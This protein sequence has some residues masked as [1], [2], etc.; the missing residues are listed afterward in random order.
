MASS[1]YHPLL[2]RLGFVD[3]A[4]LTEDRS[5]NAASTTQGRTSIHAVDILNYLLTETR[6][7]LPECVEEAY[8]KLSK[9]CQTESRGNNSGKNKIDP[10]GG[11]AL[12]VVGSKEENSGLKAGNS[13]TKM[14]QSSSLKSSTTN[15]STPDPK[16]RTRHIALQ[17]YYDGGSYSGLAEN[18][19]CDTDQSIERALFA[20]LYKAHLIPSSSR[21]SCHYSRCGRTDKGVSAAGQVVALHVKSA[22]SNYAISHN[23]EGTQLLQDDELPKNSFDKI[24]VWVPPREKQ[25]KKKDKDISGSSE[26]LKSQRMQR[27]LSELPYDKILNNLLPPDIRV[28][29]WCPVTADFSARF[30]ATTRTYRYFFIHRP[31]PGLPSSSTDAPSTDDTV[32]DRMRKGLQLMVGTHDFRNFCKMDVE[33]VYNF[34]RTIHSADIVKVSRQQALDVTSSVGGGDICYILIHGQAFLWHQVRCIASILFLVGRG[35]EEPEIVTELL[36]IKKNPGKPSYEMAD[37]RPLVLHDCGYHNLQFGY[38]VQNLWKLCCL[39]EQQWEELALAAARIR[40]TIERLREDENVCVLVDDVVDFVSNR[41]QSREDKRRRRS[42]KSKVTVTV[43]VI[44]FKSKQVR[45]KDALRWMA[46]T[47]D[48]IPDPFAAMETSYTPLL[49][50]SRGTTYEEKIANLLKQPAEASSKR[51]KKYEENVIKKRKTKE[52]DA[53]FYRHMAKQGGTNI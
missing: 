50:R 2:R 24:R 5:S 45:W 25:K 49:Q 17:I 38:S 14:G 19:G 44:P 39:Q 22:F 29:G 30:S 47:Y 7:I 11:N 13:T 32:L 52:E 8:Q 4:S 26:S 34:E 51:R 6:Q 33:K 27:D 1:V 9:Q 10:Q 12:S 43:D 37:E 48:L 21:E 23:E 20:A 18:V 15:P 3:S 16:I 28:L 41:L 35:F 46:E 36:D 42:K 40:S 31:K 53:A